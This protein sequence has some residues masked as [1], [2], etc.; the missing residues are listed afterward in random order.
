[1]FSF[2]RIIYINIMIVIIIIPNKAIYWDLERGRVYARD[3]GIFVLHKENQSDVR[4]AFLHITRMNSYEIYA[5]RAWANLFTKTT[6]YLFTKL[7]I[8]QMY[9]T[10]IAYAV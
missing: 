7:P 2:T 3:I 4:G 10:Y 1:M 9:K 5:Y 8:I 6:E